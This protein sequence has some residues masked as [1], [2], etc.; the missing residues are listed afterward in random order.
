VASLS[1]A[2]QTHAGLEWTHVG[3]EHTRDESGQPSRP[4]V[5]PTCTIGH[6]DCPPARLKWPV[7]RVDDEV[8]RMACQTVRI[9]RAIGHLVWLIA[10]VARML[11]HVLWTTAQ[12]MWPLPECLPMAERRFPRPDSHFAAYM[13]N[14]YAAV[15]KFWSVQGFDETELKPLKEALSV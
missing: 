11:G 13:N 1:A 2:V 7:Q 10:R 12:V 15:E 8:L 14:Y 4:A 6:S 9:T 3:P 5:Q